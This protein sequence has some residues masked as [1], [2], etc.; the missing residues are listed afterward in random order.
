MGNEKGES[1]VGLEDKETIGYLVLE[2]EEEEAAHS[3]RDFK[4]GEAARDIAERR[5]GNTR[6]DREGGEIGKEAENGERER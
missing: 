6:T 3:L 2:A 5:D 1:F 4:S